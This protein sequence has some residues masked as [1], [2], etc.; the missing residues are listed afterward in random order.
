M[1]ARTETGKSDQRFY[2]EDIVVLIVYQESVFT[3]L[4]VNLIL[5][6]QSDFSIP[7]HAL[8]NGQ[9]MYSVA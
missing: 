3:F 4:D 9:K 2:E 1:L 6:A 5:P 8:S 7:L